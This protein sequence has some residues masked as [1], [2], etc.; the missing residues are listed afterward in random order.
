MRYFV[1]AGEASGDAH[2]AAMVRELR[3]LDPQAEIA[4]WG[5]ERMKAEGVHIQKH[6]RDLAF[7]GFVE[8]LAHLPAILRNFKTCKEQILA[9]RPD[10]VV[11][12]DY[13]GFNLRM[14]PWAKKHGFRT[15]YYI[16]P[17]VWAWKENRMETIRRYADEMICILPFEKPF[18]ARRGMR[19]HYAG[20]PT[21]QAVEERLGQRVSGSGTPIIALLPGSRVQEIKRM[22]PVMLEAVKPF[23]AYRIQIAQAPN[24]DRSVYEPFLNDRGVELLQGKTYDILQVAHLALVTSGTATLETALFRVPQVVCYIAQ[25]LSY[26]IARMLVKVKFISLVNLILD[27][28]AVPELIQG[29]LTVERLRKECNDLLGDTPRRRTM[30]ADYEVLAGMLREGNASANAAAVVYGSVAKETHQ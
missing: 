27:R 3:R 2:G 17:T 1:I 29:G 28:E 5:G 9:F 25:P 6:I 26:A 8:V 16:S 7:M 20:H 21:V 30:L 22:L 13:P 15:V 14:L 24:L 10:T 19:V 23:S 18:Y 12:V 11:F 4:G